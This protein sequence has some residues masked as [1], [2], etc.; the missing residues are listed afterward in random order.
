MAKRPQKAPRLSVM[1]S[2]TVY[3][4]ED[5][6][7][8]IYALLTRFGY[9]VWMS[10]RGTIE[11]KSTEHAFESSLKAVESCDIFFGLITPQYGSGVPKGEIS[12]TH[13]EIIRAIELNK[14]RWFLAHEFVVFARLLMHGLGHKSAK[15]RADLA[16]DKA[17]SLDDLRV[18]DMYDAA[19]LNDVAF[20]ERKGNW[21]QKFYSN[22]DALLFATAQFHRYGEIEQFLTNHFQNSSVVTASL[23]VKSDEQ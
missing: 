2:S 20:R 1:V 15:Q 17:G 14:P 3:G 6:L 7:E 23:K 4:I 22:D 12:I 10:H 16:F 21:V 9:D 8:Q 5:L 19:T 18:I 11:V 13:Q